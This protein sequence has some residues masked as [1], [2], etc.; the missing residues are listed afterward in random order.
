MN[1][2]VVFTRG[3]SSLNGEYSGGPD[4]TMS[5]SPGTVSRWIQVWSGVSHFRTD[6]R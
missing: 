4:A 5:S 6:S 3:S 2:S 1:I